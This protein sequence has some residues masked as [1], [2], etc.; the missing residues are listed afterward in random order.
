M[1]ITAA[2]LLALMRE[3]GI[4][5]NII[6]KLDFSKPLYHQGLDSIDFPIIAAATEK[7]YNID[8][9]DA[10]ATDLK[11]VNDFVAFVNRKIK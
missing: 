3:V 6:A 9:S 2:D 4:E 8:L 10:D 7:K 1:A 11:T 5:E